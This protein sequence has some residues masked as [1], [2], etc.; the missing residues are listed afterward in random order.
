MF[1]PICEKCGKEHDG[2]YGSGR[3]CCSYCASI[4]KS[5][6]LYTPKDNEN[7]LSIPDFPDYMVSDFGNVVKKTFFRSGIVDS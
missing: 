5:V 1:L 2:T 4:R 3:F 7:F 6:R